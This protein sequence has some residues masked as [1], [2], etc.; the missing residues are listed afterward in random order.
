MRS[1]EKVRSGQREK[2]TM[3]EI[4]Q[5]K[6]S[7]LSLSKN[8]GTLAV[9]YSNNHTAWCDHQSR[10]KFYNLERNDDKLH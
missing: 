2:I 10:I 4:K 3:E 1:R 8:G 7:S 9:A 5:K 6:I